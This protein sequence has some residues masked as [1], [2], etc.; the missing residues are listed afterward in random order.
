VWV[1]T[2]DNLHEQWCQQIAK[3]E[4]LSTKQNQLA[5]EESVQLQC[6]Q[7]FEEETA[8]MEERKKN[9]LKYS[10]ILMR[11]R[12]DTNEDKT[13]IS[14]FVLKKLYKSHFIELYY[15]TNDSLEETLSL[16]RTPG[17][18]TD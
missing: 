5:E 13:F 18:M 1:A 14:E 15:W 3:D 10:E 17:T 11:P 6:A 8:R 7:V 2:N 16:L 4:C 12:P 9:C